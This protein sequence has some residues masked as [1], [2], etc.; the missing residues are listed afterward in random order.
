MNKRIAVAN[1]TAKAQAVIG[2]YAD[3]PGI[4]RLLAELPSKCL[5]LVFID[6]TE[7]NVPFATVKTIVH[8]LK[9]ADL[10]INVALGTDVTRNLHLAI[11]GEGFSKV[12]AKYE[13]FLG[14]PGF[15]QRPEMVQLA[16]VGAHEELRR[17]FMDQFITSLRGEGYLYTDFR[18]VEHYYNLLFASRSPKGLEFWKKACSIGPDNQRELLQL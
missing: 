6:P 14:A 17:R 18:P 11:T 8:Q 10:I 5:N 2:N 16:Q 15:C 7:C 1:A 12:R 9:N 4:Q 3:A 13:S